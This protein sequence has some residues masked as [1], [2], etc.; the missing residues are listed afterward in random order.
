MSQ[1]GSTSIRWATAI[2]AIGLLAILGIA[3]QP[4]S[5]DAE[6]PL[7][8]AIPADPQTLDPHRAEGTASATVLMDLYEGLVREDP[9]GQVVAGAAERWSI[10]DDGLIYTFYLRENLRWSN[11]D[12][13]VA[14]DYA[15][16]LRRTIDPQTASAY[17]PL[18]R[19]VRNAEAVAAGTLPLEDAGIEATSERTLQIELAQPTPFF[20]GLLTHWA[21]FPLHRPSFAAHGSAFVRPEHSITNGAYTLRAQRVGDRISLEKNTNYWDAANVSIE[22]VEFLPLENASTELRLFEAGELDITSSTPANQFR[23]LQA[24]YGDQ[25]HVTPNLSVYFMVFDLSEPPFSDVRVREALTIAL[26]RDALTKSVLASG[27]AGAWGLVPPGIA[28]H[29]SFSY[30]WREWPREQQIEYAREQLA[31]AG[32][33]AASTL[34]ATLLY[35]TGDTHQK[36]AIALQG[37]ARDTLGIELDIINQEFKVMLDNRDKR[38]QWDL[39]RLGWTGDYNDADTFLSLFR[40]GHPQNFAGY[41]N[42]DFD[43]LLDQAA[44]TVDMSARSVLMHQAEKM[45]VEDYPVLPMYFYVSRHLVSER[46]E[47]FSATPM[48]RTYSAHLSLTELP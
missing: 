25:L 43:A 23:A 46:V 3:C 12:P 10:S 9:T 13:V 15:A 18:L 16:G 20:L 40:S 22:Q 36:I 39:M 1:M 29:E 44:G 19:P 11:G 35:N 7:R 30:V 41:D 38:D 26:D 37:M 5:D 24:T 28:N 48:N 4:K 42:A 8:R 17:A 2:A 47:D 21:T 27:Q 14:E 45:V 31:A 33:D 34:R 6:L 32:Y